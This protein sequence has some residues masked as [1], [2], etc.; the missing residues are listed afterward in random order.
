MPGMACFT[1]SVGLIGLHM[2]L[3]FYAYLMMVIGSLLIL[4][5]FFG[6]ILI[7]AISWH[8]GEFGRFDRA[9]KRRIKAGREALKGPLTHEDWLAW[10]RTTEAMLADHLGGIWH[11]EFARFNAAGAYGQEDLLESQK[12]LVAKQINTLSELRNRLREQREAFVL[13][14]PKLR[15]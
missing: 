2:H 13:F 7:P 12:V 9:I 1:L 6:V 11:P 10:L 3:E 14:T 8:C 15:V 5:G 4:S